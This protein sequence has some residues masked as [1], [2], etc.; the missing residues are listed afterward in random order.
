MQTDD[1]LFGDPSISITGPWIPYHAEIRGDF[2]CWNRDYDPE[3]PPSSTNIFA[4]AVHLMDRGSS[5]ANLK[6]MLDA[7]IGL[8]NEQDVLRFVKTFGTLQLCT[9]GDPVTRVHSPSASLDCMP[10]GWSDNLWCERIDQWLSYV[11]VADGIL[12]VASALHQDEQAPE[13]YWRGT[14]FILQGPDTVTDS[15]DPRL[16][17]PNGQVNYK[18]IAG[19]SVARQQK[20]LA[21]LVEAWLSFGDIQF[22]FAWTPSGPDFGL[23][24]NTF[25]TLGIQLMMAV[26]S[27]QRFSIC[28]LCGRLYARKNKP[29]RRR[30][31]YCDDCKTRG[32]T[33]RKQAQRAK[34]KRLKEA[35][36]G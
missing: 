30:R 3:D 32:S 14:N 13:E 1:G 7:F 20:H 16:T 12:K 24:G 11:Q 2:I 36:D 22:D 35:T 10:E 17:Y 19:R 6:R 23:N 15:D 18:W 34:E 26:S 31:N 28:S 5:E 29:Q 9:K 4:A 21:L 27:R 25:S 33:L 8:K